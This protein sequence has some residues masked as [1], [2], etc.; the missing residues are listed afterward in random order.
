MEHIIVIK[1][2]KYAEEHNLL[3]TLQ[4]GFRAKRSCETQ[5]ISFIDDVSKNL[6]KGR[7]TGDLIMDF[8]KAFDKVDHDLLIYKLNSHGITGNVNHWIK[9]FLSNRQQAVMFEGEKS[10][11]VPVTSGVPQ[12]SVLGP[13]LFLF[14]INDIANELDS[15]VRLFAD[16]TMVYLVVKSQSDAKKLQKDLDCFGSWERDWRM[17]L[18]PDKCSVLSITRSKTP[19]H[20]EYQL[21]GQPLEHV[22]SAKCLG[23]T[24]QSDLKFP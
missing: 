12:G 4:H 22:K 13:T 15:T 20:Y 24:I 3:Y 8:S 17:E 1:I 16:D 6:E 9:N 21:H 11:F 23:V 5:L 14:Y 7:Q 2:M 10:D 19:I 18:H